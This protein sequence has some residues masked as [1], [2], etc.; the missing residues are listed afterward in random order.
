MEP[1][2]SRQEFIQLMARAGDAT[3][4]EALLARLGLSDKEQLTEQD[5]SAL[6]VAANTA[7]GEL[8]G[9]RPNGDPRKDDHMRAMLDALNGH[10]IPLMAKQFGMTKQGNNS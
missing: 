7:A 8:L 10:A 5:V 9:N 4:A 6:M 3:L 2:V 1:T